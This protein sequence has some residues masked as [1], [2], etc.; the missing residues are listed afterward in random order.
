MK[1]EYNDCR[2]LF[3]WRKKTRKRGCGKRK[4]GAE[5]LI[6]GEEKDRKKG[7]WVGSVH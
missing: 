2:P 6:W 7:E 5:K 4:R 1:M 3:Q